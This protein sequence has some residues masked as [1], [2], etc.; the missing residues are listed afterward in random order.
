MGCS[1][2]E[3]LDRFWAAVSKASKGVGGAKSHVVE[4]V[5]T[6][7]VP[8]SGSSQ[9]PS[10]AALGEEPVCVCVYV[11]IPLI[12]LCLCVCVC[13]CVCVCRESMFV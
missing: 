7:R 9:S 1:N 6:R 5:V 12:V 10:M 3:A 4:L 2:K 11:Y 13:V 8:N